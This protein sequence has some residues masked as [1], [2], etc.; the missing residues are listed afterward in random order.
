MN[1]L[2]E[3]RKA[4]GMRQ[5]ELAQIMEVSQATLSNW[6]R[7]VH[8]LDNESLLKLARIFGC[9][10]DYLLGYSANVEGDDAQMEQ[11]YYRIAQDAKNSGISPHDLQLALDFLKKA[12]ERDNNESG[13]IF[14]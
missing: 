6:E 5:A 7:G 12:R 4:K 9:T 8:D 14:K 10:T 11:I 2:A 1:R 3:L 13:Q